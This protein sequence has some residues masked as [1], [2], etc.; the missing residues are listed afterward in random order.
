MRDAVH[1]ASR[2]I[3][4]FPLRWLLGWRVDPA[5]DRAGQL[6]GFGPDAASPLRAITQTDAPILLMHG[7][8][9][10]YI[11]PSNSQ[12]LPDAAPGHSKLIWI[13]GKGHNIIMEGDSTTRVVRAAIDW[14]DQHMALA[15]QMS[16]R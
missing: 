8:T 1:D 16:L 11:S 14:F 3:L 6:A 9:D 2:A 12:R 5:I 15:H 4:P 13:E 7:T 10:K